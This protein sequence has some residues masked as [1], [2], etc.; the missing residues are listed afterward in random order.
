MSEGQWQEELALDKDTAAF[1]AAVRGAFAS[2]NIA[3]MTVDEVVSVLMNLNVKLEPPKGVSRRTWMLGT[4]IML[5]ADQANGHKREG[6][7]RAEHRLFKARSQL[8]RA[9]DFAAW[10]KWL[11]ADAERL[12]SDVR[13]AAAT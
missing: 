4:A 1:V 7:K 9:A 10:R 11:G 5:F 6:A 2:R 12:L 8:R 13:P 3:T